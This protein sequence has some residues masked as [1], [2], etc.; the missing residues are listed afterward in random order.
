M[1]HLGQT[2]S[3]KTFFIYTLLCLKEELKFACPS[4]FQMHIVELIEGKADR[5]TLLHCLIRGIRNLGHV[6]KINCFSS[7]C[8]QKFGEGGGYL[9]LEVKGHMR[10]FTCVKLGYKKESRGKQEQHRSK[11]SENK[12]KNVFNLS[13]DVRMLELSFIFTILRL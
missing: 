10:L 8:L 13:M 6:N 7:F 4:V 11:K 9:Y 5:T 3:H 2:I 1:L 12:Q